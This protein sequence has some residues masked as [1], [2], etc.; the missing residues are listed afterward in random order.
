MLKKM[1]NFDLTPRAKLLAYVTAALVFVFIFEKLFF[2]PLRVRIKTVDKQ[3]K[4]KELELKTGVAIQNKKESIMEDYKKYKS[5]L[6]DRESKP[7][8]ADLV[9]KFLKELENIAQRT[10]V[11]I[12]NLTPD[13]QIRTLDGNKIFYADA[14]IE[15]T[16]DQFYSF[17]SEIQSSKLLI[18]IDKMAVSTK[19]ENASALRMDATISMTAI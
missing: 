19:D 8:D 9:A 5:Y 2:A 18:K 10:H 6:Q 12:V 4:L 1:M 13:D 15:V 11:S 3:I 17:L 7:S 14:R 16:L